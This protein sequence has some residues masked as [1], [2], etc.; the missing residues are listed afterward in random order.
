M[1]RLINGEGMNRWIYQF[2]LFSAILYLALVEFQIF[3]H[4]RYDILFHQMPS[5]LSWYSLVSVM[6]VCW[7]SVM[8]KYHRENKQNAAF[9]I[10]VIL[11]IIYASRFVFLFQYFITGWYRELYIPSYFL[12]LGANLAYAACLAFSNTRKIILLRV[13]GIFSLTI[14]I[15]WQSH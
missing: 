7:L 12:M 11:A 3:M 10:G 5:F 4:L 2:G 14:T 6:Y 13:A 9:T 15:V 1:M 8:L